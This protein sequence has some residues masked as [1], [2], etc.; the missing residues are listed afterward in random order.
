MI[1]LHAPNGD[2]IYVRAAA[3]DVVHID[4]VSVGAKTEILTAGGATI[5]VKE[6]K[7]EVK[8]LMEQEK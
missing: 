2:E 5:H 7:E 4:Y 3:I 8:A 6:T 1:T